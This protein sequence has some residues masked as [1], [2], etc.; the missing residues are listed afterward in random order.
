[1]NPCLFALARSR[2]SPTLV[3]RHAHF[4]PRARRRR[5]DGGD[6]VGERISANYLNQSKIAYVRCASRLGEPA[7]GENYYF[8]RRE[9]RR[10]IDPAGFGELRLG[11]HVGEEKD[12]Q[13]A[14]RHWNSRSR[15]H[16]HSLI[17]SCLIITQHRSR[18]RPTSLAN[19]EHEKI[20]IVSDDFVEPSFEE[21]HFTVRYRFAVT[22]RWCERFNEVGHFPLC[23]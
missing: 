1:M 14:R 10:L 15:A 2:C 12:A 22:E 5:P 13:K 18:E 11:G 7:R 21:N 3:F 17:D 20:I 16:T 9:P 6:E 23:C 4:H 19:I 8:P